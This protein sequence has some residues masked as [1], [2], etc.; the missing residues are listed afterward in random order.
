MIDRVRKFGVDAALRD[1]YNDQKELRYNDALQTLDAILLVD[2]SN[3]ASMALRDIIRA[4][5]LYRDYADIQKAMEYSLSSLTDGDLGGKTDQSSGRIEF[6]WQRARGGGDQSPTVVRIQHANAEQL[7][8]ELNGLLNEAG[9]GTGLERPASGLSGQGLGGLAEPT[10][11]PGAQNNGGIELSWAAG[12]GDPKSVQ[13]LINEGSQFEHPTATS[14]SMTYPT[15]WPQL[16][17]RRAEGFAPIALQQG[18]ASHEGSSIDYGVAVGS[19]TGVFGEL[20]SSRRSKSPVTVEAVDGQDVLFVTGP[21]EYRKTM[22]QLIRDLDNPTAAD[23][24]VLNVLNTQHIQIDFHE[25]TLEQV[26]D[27]FKQVTGLKMFAN[28]KALQP[29]G[30]LPTTQITLVIADLKVADAMTRILSTLGSDI[31]RPIHVVRDGIVEITTL[32]AIRLNSGLPAAEK[33]DIS[34]DH[35]TPDAKRLNRLRRI[36]DQRLWALVDELV[37]K[38]GS[39]NSPVIA[40]SLVLAG[41]AE[42]IGIILSVRDAQDGSLD[43]IRAAGLHIE[44]IAQS[45]KVIAGSVDADKLDDLAMLECVRRIEPLTQ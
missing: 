33:P 23:Q 30:V 36:I 11:V 17:M 1:V 16:T 3:Q 27:F 6:P 7:A 25:N 40:T 29:I 21:P 42:E 34:Q 37:P 28:W 32:D 31:Q 8:R 10:S 5:M 18:D 9:S 19:D 4:T 15:D 12:L 14:G 35:G 20:T 45:Q 2:P 26:F 39:N 24:G 44:D 41:T 22:E 38:Q 43:Q 13:E